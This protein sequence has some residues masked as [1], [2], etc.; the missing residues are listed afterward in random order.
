V[1]ILTLVIETADSFYDS[2]LRVYAEE[3]GIPLLDHVC[4]LLLCVRII[5]LEMIALALKP[6]KTASSFPP[7]EMGIIDDMNNAKYL[8]RV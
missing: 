5:G 7:H 4:N 1:L 8:S 6:S 2:G 3:F